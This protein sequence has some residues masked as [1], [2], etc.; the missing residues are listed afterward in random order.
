MERAMKQP[1]L[2]ILHYRRQLANSACPDSLQEIMAQLVELQMLTAEE[3]HHFQE[4]TPLTRRAEALMDTLGGKGR[5][6]LQGLQTCIENSRFNLYLRMRHYDPLVKKHLDSVEYDQHMLLAQL[7]HL[8]L[9]EGLTDAQ[10]QEHDIIQLELGQA[11]RGTPKRITLEKLLMPLSRVSLPP[12]ITL[13]IGVAGAGKSTLVRLFVEKWVRGELCTNI[14]CLL[15]LNLWELNTFE[16]LSVEKLMRIACPQYAM[17]PPNSLLILDGLDQLRAPLDF[18]DSIGST[19]PQKE[20]SPECLITNILRGNLLPDVTVWVTSRPGA[21]ASIPAGLVDR[22]TEIPGLEYSEINLYMAQVLHET[23]GMVKRVCGYLELHRALNALCSVPTLCYI[24]G[25]S[26]ACAMCSNESTF[27]SLPATLSIIFS[28]YL[29]SQFTG[30]EGIEQPSS[31]RR[32]VGNLGK[33]AFLGLLKRRSVFY[34]SDLKSCGI[35]MPILPGSLCAR[36]LVSQNSPYCT[37][38]CFSH[39]LLQEF[40]AAIHYYSAAK[41]AIFDL[42]AEAAVSWP[43]LGFLNHYKN[44]TQRTLQLDGIHLSIFLRFLSGIL[45]PQVLKVLVGCLP[46]KEDSSSHRGQVVDY[47]QNCLSGE[48]TI[49]CAIVNLMFCLYEIGHTEAIRVVEEALRR[50]TLRKKINPLNCCALAFLLRTSYSCVQETNLSQCLNYSLVKNF[51]PQLQYCMNLKME[52]NNFRDDVME[53]LATILRAKDCAIQKI[54]LA[55]NR[56]GNRG[57]KLLA[58]ALMVNHTT[59][60]LDLHGNIIGPSG[61]RALAEALRSNQ[62]LLNLNLQN[63]QIKSE[64]AQYLADSLLLNQTLRSLNIKSNSIGW[65]GAENL[66]ACLKKNMVLQEL[67]LSSNPLGDKGASALAGALMANSSLI[68]LDLQSNS[69]SNHGLKSLTIGLGQN[70]GLKNLNLRENSISSE[71]ARALAEALQTNTTLTHLDLTANLLHDQ[72]V[73]ALSLALKENQTLDTLHL[74]WNFLRVGSARSLAG[75]L[76]VNQGLHSLDLQEN[77]I[78]DEGISILSKALQENTTL[79]ALYLQGTAIGPSGAQSLAEAL[80][81]N[82]SL[83]TLD[84]RGNHIG[85]PGAKAL[86]GALR[87]NCTLQ[88]L[89]LQENAIGLDGAICLAHAISGNSSLISLSLQ[90]NSIGQSGAK[91]IA[92]VLKNDAPRCTVTIEDA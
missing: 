76:C 19:D 57:V 52:N 25:V 21:A 20:M 60:L 32:T 1:G 54:S 91:V 58:K 65:E 23:N 53:L 50:E 46:N 35:E 74:Q 2:W 17:P 83:T 89:N 59:S 33:L 18:S 16:R 77:A 79:S 68:N 26:L 63:N 9:V 45:S 24:I 22:L 4:I 3:I 48:Q 36:L 10:L 43:K 88:V 84:L 81:V 67:W 55:E 12:Q 85:L 11:G 51:L 13:T 47:L 90:G 7:D 29:K 56:L 6:Y 34:E 92:D 5:G 40:L 41:R 87:V 82:K 39:L 75:A 42:F 61:A 80:L 27:S 64:G 71:G 37:S 31:A 38:F 44:V 30:L 73:E 72:G 78:S 8:L 70:R 49:S 15:T 28:W 14:S 62:V 69:I 66:A 86:A